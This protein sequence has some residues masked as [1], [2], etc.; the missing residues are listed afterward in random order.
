MEQRVQCV[1]SG[2]AGYVYVRLYI[3]LGMKQRLE[4][5][6]SIKRPFK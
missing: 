1:M 6:P 2:E 4:E 5:E 3:T